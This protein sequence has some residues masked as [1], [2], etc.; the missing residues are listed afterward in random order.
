M[1]LVARY[2]R[3][4]DE[5]PRLRTRDAARRLGVSELELVVSGVEGPARLLRADP[6]ALLRGLPAVGRAMALT[7]NEDVVHERHGVWGRPTFHGGGKVG[8]V[9]GPDI[10]LRLF[11]HRWSHLVALSAAGPRGPRHSIQVFDDHG[12]A[13]H[14]VF[15]TSETD[16]AAW[17]ALIADL[18][19]GAPT[20]IE[21]VAPAPPPPEVRPDADIDAAALEARWRALTDTHDFFGMLRDVGAAREQ[22]LR[23]VP[24][25]LAREVPPDALGRVLDAAAA[26]GLSIM[27]FVGNPGAIQIHT[28]PVQRIVRIPGWLNV[29]DDDFNLHVREAGLARAWVVRKPGDTGLVHSLEVFDAQ[30]ELLVQLFV[31]RKPGIPEQPE[32][33]ELVLGL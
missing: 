4:K 5:V 26:T 17:D 6:Q 16:A 28:G 13:V 33:A 19:V 12:V 15:A 31:A 22:A 30:G 32:W 8:L 9:V 14:K 10:D 3:L 24:D 29:L 27:V 7:R 2:A 20:E 18:S 23:L 25:D 21:A 11:L 1:N